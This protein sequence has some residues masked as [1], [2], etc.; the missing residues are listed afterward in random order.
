[1]FTTALSTHPYLS[2]PLSSASE[3]LPSSI[4]THLAFTE[5][6]A[7]DAAQVDQRSRPLG[8]VVVVA[9]LTPGANG[10]PGRPISELHQWKIDKGS[11]EASGAADEGAADSA[12]DETAMYLQSRVLPESV[13]TALEP[14]VGS[15][16][17]VLAME[18][19][20]QSWTDGQMGSFRTIDL[21]DLQNS[22]T[23]TAAPLRAKPLQGHHVPTSFNTTPNS[24]FVVLL[25]ASASSVAFH[26][27][28]T[29]SEIPRDADSQL[30]S[31]TLCRLMA[32]ALYQGSGVQDLVKVLPLLTAS[33]EGGGKKRKLDEE[34]EPLPLLHSIDQR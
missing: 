12:G 7:Q 32:L 11:P 18:V 17:L 19:N 31:T 29:L 2:V 22:T 15:D 21:A 24:S 25:G 34:G 23:V 6:P 28:P 16:S 30:V 3:L 20:S 1:M 13:L 33:L 5:L 27:H 26:L 14:I 10:E 4:V 9:D 8:L